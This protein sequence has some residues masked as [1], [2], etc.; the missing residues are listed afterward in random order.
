M[1]QKF[2][3]K[4]LIGF[5][6]LM[7]IILTPS[8][9][10]VN[11]TID[12]VSQK[13]VESGL[14]TAQKVFLKFLQVKRSNYSH[15]VDTFI[16]TQPTLR[17]ILGTSGGTSDDLFGDEEL[18]VKDDRDKKQ[19]QSKA[20]SKEI[21]RQLFST[22]EGLDI[23]AASALFIICNKRGEIL[24]NKVAPDLYGSMMP[25]DPIIQIAL[26]GNP[27]ASF[28]H[29]ESPALKALK[30]FPTTTDKA[31]Y[32]VFLRPIVFGQETSGLIIVGFPITSEDLAEVKEVSLADV[33]FVSSGKIFGSTHASI[34]LLKYLETNSPQNSVQNFVD[35]KEEYIAL[36][37]T[38]QDSL[39]RPVAS[40]ILYRSKTKEMEV[41][42]NL[43]NLLGTIGL[44]AVLLAILISY[45]FSSSI[46]QSIRILMQGVKAI[47][48]GNLDHK[49]QVPGR[50]ELSTLANDF[51]VM[52]QE[53]KEKEE[54][55]K[56]FKRYVNPS[57]VATLLE[58]ASKLKLGG[59]RRH[60]LI[61]FADIAGFTTIS[62]KLPP[63]KVIEFLNQYLSRATRA[64]ENKK[65]IVDK[66]I[67]DAIVAYWILPELSQPA[68]ST[69]RDKI[70]QLA[71]QV[72]LEQLAIV[73]ELRKEWSLILG[74]LESN[75]LANFDIR[76]G[77]HAG[78]AILGN[79]G[80]EE[81]MDYT[82]VGDSVNT[83]ARLESINKL[84]GSHILV[85]ETIA[86]SIRHLFQFRELDFIRVFGR[87]TSLRIFEL[88]GSLDHAQAVT[89]QDFVQ[90]FEQA[91]H[92]Y[93]EG[94]FANAVTAFQA[95]KLA[96]P[97]DPPTQEFLKRSQYLATHPPENWDGVYQALIK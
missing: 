35:A 14:D 11:S 89:S 27:V 40:A 50:D 72:A 55:K 81:R 60:L 68:D 17:A 5:I 21:N 2:Q 73:Q 97:F 42:S 70:Y 33:A 4:L 3:H 67:G 56:T 8:L 58:D 30:L 6:L 90:A 20:N 69:E 82:M 12:R 45:F 75:A 52:T 78:N 79:I 59:D 87:T 80:S 10:L 83:T 18:V 88:M 51:N 92:L 96:H 22:V 54:I 37:S 24:L 39:E 36:V 46:T 41:F 85:S 7:A 57:V 44:I 16:H 62:E 71:C 66:Y 43:K 32:N 9:I 77:M 31:I 26:Q 84:Y 86:P 29:S 63:E 95:L 13:R 28:W 65:G 23:Y 93:L 48:S 64:I 19:N 47:R 94:D 49:V 76:I 25:P 91:L 15:L 74:N 1:I 61:Y 38:L 34:P 53:L